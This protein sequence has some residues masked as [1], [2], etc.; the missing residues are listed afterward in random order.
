[1]NDH[2]EVKFE[3]ASGVITSEGWFAYGRLDT[4]AGIIEW[5]GRLNVIVGGKT[6]ELNI[7]AN[8]DGKVTALS[9][10]SDILNFQGNE[11]KTLEVSFDPPPDGY[12]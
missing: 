4:T 2:Q 8:S 7:S 10:H 11:G 6:L 5:S 12:R 3:S 9:K 1:M